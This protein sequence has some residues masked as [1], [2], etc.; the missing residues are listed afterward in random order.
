MFWVSWEVDSW[1]LI[2]VLGFTMCICYKYLLNILLKH[3]K[4]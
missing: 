1:V 2:I 3:N 4:E